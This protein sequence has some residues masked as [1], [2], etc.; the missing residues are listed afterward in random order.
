MAN[1]PVRQSEEAARGRLTARPDLAPKQVLDAG[2]HSVS[3]PGGRDG[4]L[5]VPRGADSANGLPLVVSL[6][7]AGGNAQHGVSML[8]G[9]ADERGF[10]ILSPASRRGTWDVIV[11]GYGPDVRALNDLL[12]YTFQH[13]PVRPEAVAI[14]GFSDGAS[15]ALSLGLVNGDLFHHI[16]AFSPGFV[17]SSREQDRPRVFIS[18]G[19]HD[20]VLPIDRCSRVIVPRLRRAGYAVDYREFDGPHTV[21]ADMKDEAIRWW[22]E[23][24]SRG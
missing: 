18:H 10:A 13:L 2:L 1:T 4:L 3:V 6:H 16:L 21:P 19:T 14:S 5:Y 9:R 12:L 23:G 7:G 8:E 20:T 22:Y 11:D 24:A 17:A 15:Y